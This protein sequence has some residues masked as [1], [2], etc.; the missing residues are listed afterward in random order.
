MNNST[1]GAPFAPLTPDGILPPAIFS[2][3]PGTWAHDTVS[4][5]LRENILSRVFS[6]NTNLLG[7]WNPEADAALKTAGRMST[8]G[9][10]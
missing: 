10:S 7:G 8:A 2:N 4:R 1:L 3:E 6:D 9:G 5:R